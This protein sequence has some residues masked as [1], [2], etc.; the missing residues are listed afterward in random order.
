MKT[1]SPDDG[2][3][4][5]IVPPLSP[6]LQVIMIR[7]Y[8]LQGMCQ[9]QEAD[10]DVSRSGIPALKSYFKLT[11]HLLF[12]DILIGSHPCDS[13]RRWRLQ[14]AAS[15]IG[16][17]EPPSY[18]SL[19]LLWWWRSEQYLNRSGIRPNLIMGQTIW[20]VTVC[21][22]FYGAAPRLEY[23]GSRLKTLWSW[24]LLCSTVSSPTY[25]ARH[26]HFQKHLRLLD[27]FGTCLIQLALTNREDCHFKFQNRS[28]DAKGVRSQSE[29][30]LSPH[31]I[32][33]PPNCDAH[34]C[35]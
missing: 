33:C 22:L 30:S 24:C 4:K 5:R 11:L 28:W 9:P 15:C 26:F 29:D 14:S 31:C 3:W 25:C 21:S 35:T 17:L 20:Q 32:E 6:K 18:V 27:R 16:N 34:H 23:F 19:L 13:L 8:R 1:E 12:A 7:S 10:R 2:S